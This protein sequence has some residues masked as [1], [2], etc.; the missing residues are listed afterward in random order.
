MMD[1]MYIIVCYINTWNDIV[2]YYFL[3]YKVHELIKENI[4]FLFYT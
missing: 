4:Y 2:S 3:Y 1:Y